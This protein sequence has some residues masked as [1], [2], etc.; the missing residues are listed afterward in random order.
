[1]FSIRDGNTANCYQKRGRKPRTD[2]M[3]DPA[4]IARRE[5]ALARMKAA[6]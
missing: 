2:Y 5:K 6:E 3:N 1:M 4:V